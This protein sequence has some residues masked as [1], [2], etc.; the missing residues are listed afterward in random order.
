LD[1][2][3]KTLKDVSLIFDKPLESSFVE[4]VSKHK[5]SDVEVTKM[6]E[7]LAKSTSLFFLMSS[8]WLL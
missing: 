3:Q 5:R 6:N 7:T 1:A 4:K 2:L 8:V